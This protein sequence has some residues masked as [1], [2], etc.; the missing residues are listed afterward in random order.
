M[1]QVQ[2]NWTTKSLQTL[3]S[4]TVGTTCHG[5]K[6]WTQSNTFCKN[7]KMSSCWLYVVAMGTH[8]VR[9]MINCGVFDSVIQRVPRQHVVLYVLRLCNLCYFTT[10]L[11][12]DIVMNGR[13]IPWNELIMIHTD[14]SPGKSGVITIWSIIRW[15]FLL[16]EFLDSALSAAM[17]HLVAHQIYEETGSQ[18]PWKHNEKSRVLDN[19]GMQQ[20]DSSRRIMTKSKIPSTTTITG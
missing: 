10:N 13:C 18:T 19:V 16:K 14:T 20:D 12:T 5:V 6:C 1:N 15:Y 4:R 17:H 7:K 2:V 9:G 3:V 11:E 8:S